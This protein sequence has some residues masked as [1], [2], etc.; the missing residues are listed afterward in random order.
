MSRYRVSEPDTKA[1]EKYG[2]NEQWRLYLAI[3]L[4]IF[5]V[6]LGLRL[7]RWALT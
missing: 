6:C 7:R 3:L 1:F 4:G 5:A 2:I